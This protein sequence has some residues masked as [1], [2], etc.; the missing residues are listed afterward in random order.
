MGLDMYARTSIYHTE[1]QV[2]LESHENDV[3]IHNWRKHPDMHGWME[4]LYRERGGR[5]EN[6][7]CT[8]VRLKA[9]DL[10]ALERDV[11]AGLLP[12]TCGFFFGQSDGSER[13]DDL[14]F[15]AKAREA[16]SRGLVVYSTS[17]W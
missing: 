8:S 10:D 6:F 4:R 15:V 3:E 5:D 1:R 9:A 11:R 14:R 2:D 12:H 16:L 7:N 17:W 13:A